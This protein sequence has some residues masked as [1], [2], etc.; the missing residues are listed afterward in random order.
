VQPRQ[1]ALVQA[2]QGRA[3]FE[4]LEHRKPGARR[5]DIL[6]RAVER[7]EKRSRRPAPGQAEPLERRT[8]AHAWRRLHLG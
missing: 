5:L 3:A 6:E 4:I 7:D 8:G 1:L 2:G